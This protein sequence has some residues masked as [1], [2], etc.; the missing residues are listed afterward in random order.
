MEVSI[1]SG[2]NQ[3]SMSRGSFKY[4]QKI[5]GKRKLTL[6]NQEKTEEGYLLT[7]VD[8]K[9]S[10]AKEQVHQFAVTQQ[11][12][13]IRLAYVGEEK[14]GVNRY[15]LTFVTNPKEHIYGCGETYSELDLKGQNVRIWVAEHQN[16]GRIS[17]KIIKEKLLGKHPDKKLSFD[18]YESYYAQPT[19]VSSDK[20]YVHCDI[21]AY[22]EF[23]FTD[24]GKITLYF[25]EPPVI[26]TDSGQDFAEV[27]RKL[28]GLL[29]RQKALPD[30]LYDGVIL[31]IQEGT[32]VVDAKI[33]KAKE[34]G[35]PVVGVW[36]QDWSGC[37]RTGFGYQVMWNWEWD[38]ELYPGL[39]KKIAEWKEEGVRFLGY[40]NP[41]IAIEKDL[42]AYASEHGYCVQDREGKDYLVTITTFPAAMVDFTNP[43]AYEWY[44]GLIK[45]NMIG[46]GMGGWMA[47]FGEYLPIDA[48]LYSGEDPAIIHNQ[49]P[50]IW[51]KMNQEAVAECGKEGQVFFFT[52]AGH[53]GT[54][55]HS[56]MM[57]T[58]DQHVDWSIDDGLPAVIPATL[59]LAMSGYGIAHSDVGGYTTIMHMRR[60]KELLLRW[61]EMNVFS[62]LFRT[63]EGNQ[64]VNNVQFDDDEELLA[65]LAK[66]GRMHVALKDYLKGLVAEEISDGTPVMRPLFYHYDEAE[67]YTEK[68][69]YLLGRD[70]LVA[71]VY[72]EG[73]KSRT[74]YLPSDGWVNIFD[75]KEYAGGHMI[76]EAPIGK[77]PVFVRKD[78]KDY[79]ALMQVA[80][81]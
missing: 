47:D 67:A 5:S 66:C 29:G 22:S 70:L 35:V 12:S 2:E 15:W 52:R 13:Q 50:A 24:A 6:Q 9:G 20:Y 17:K 21:N 1:G 25:Q 69:E 61:E 60:S 51:A 43:E 7:Y 11:G 10:G 18:K 40:I 74:I 27:S 63:H 37:R 32:D 30:W 46:L 76:V 75:G 49:W 57:W 64:P 45:E 42:Y 48:V 28:T 80:Q 62:P 38:Q 81:A 14:P 78:S 31:G 58:G 23:D 54:I 68:T 73:A 16:T 77:P 8:P 4:K 39:D 55:A 36:C 72:E 33:K 71:P 19:F 53:T 34:A 79:E 44:K 41:F 3:F 59:S 56:H 65:Q 26:I